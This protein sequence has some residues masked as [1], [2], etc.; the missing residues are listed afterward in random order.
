MAKLISRKSTNIKGKEW[1]FV[2]GGGEDE[3]NR[4]EEIFSSSDRVAV[5]VGNAY[6]DE[7]LTE[8]LKA[9]LVNDKNTQ[10]S[11]FDPRGGV[12]ST[13]GAK[14]DMAFLLGLISREVKAS[15]KGTAILRNKFAHHSA[16]G[17]FE[18]LSLKAEK[19]KAINRDLQDFKKKVLKL[20]SDVSV[21]NNNADT[22]RQLYSTIL[23]ILE[24]ELKATTDIVRKRALTEQQGTNSHFKHI[25]IGSLT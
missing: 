4:L 25:S 5:I 8:L 19:D 10:N 16:F 3:A 20:I 2:S 15:L 13:F 18:S 17:S 12:I 22:L 1:E 7:L 11:F 23:P 14:V 21:P 9:F 6:L 24:T